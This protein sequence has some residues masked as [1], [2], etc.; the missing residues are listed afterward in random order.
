LLSD[1]AQSMGYLDISMALRPFTM[2]E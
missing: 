2:G 1:V